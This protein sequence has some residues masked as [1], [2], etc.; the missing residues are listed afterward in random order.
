MRIQPVRE[1]CRFLRR[2]SIVKKQDW[3]LIHVSPIMSAILL[4]LSPQVLGDGWQKKISQISGFTRLDTH[5]EMKMWLASKGPLVASM[6]VYDD[7]CLYK[8]GVYEY[9]LGNEIGLHVV[10]CI[11]YDDMKH[12][13]LCKNSFGTDWGEDGYFWIHYGDESGLDSHMFGING[14]SKIYT[15]GG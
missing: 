12:A 6:A 9:T 10:C 15:L 11:G 2:W 3:S 14:F 13:W 7:L 5:H 4:L 8:G 1:G